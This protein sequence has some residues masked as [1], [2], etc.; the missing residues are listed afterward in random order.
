MTD[1]Q[2]LSLVRDRTAVIEVV[3]TV[4]RALDAK[5]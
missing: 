5:D 2:S 1:E 4:A 3:L